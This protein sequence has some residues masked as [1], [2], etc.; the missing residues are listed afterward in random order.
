MDQLPQH[1]KLLHIIDS[2]SAQRDGIFNAKTREITESER[3]NIG[4]ELA[5]EVAEKENEMDSLLEAINSIT[6]SI[7]LSINKNTETIVVNEPPSHFLF[8]HPRAK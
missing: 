7:D 3:Q 4:H 8:N 1:K 6:S 5:I 2:H